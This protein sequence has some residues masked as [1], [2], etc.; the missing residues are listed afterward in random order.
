LQKDCGVPNYPPDTFDEY[1]RQTGETLKAWSPQQ[2]LAF[3]AALAERWLQAYEKFSAAAGQG[4]PA[5]LRPLVDAV[6]DHLRGR[7]LA[8]TDAARFLEQ[9]NENAPDTEAFDRL[10]AWRALQAC[11]ILALALECCQKTENAATVVKAVR[12]AFEAVLGGCPS[13]LAGQRRAW[14]KKTVQEEFG[15]QSALIEAI[16]PIGRFDDQ[17]IARLRSGLGPVVPL[18]RAGRTKSPSKRKRVDND[19]IE[20]WCLAVRGYLKRS[21]E[22]R[23]AFVAALAE[24]LLPLYQSFVAA[25]GQGRPELL[26]SVLEAVWQAAKGQPVAA[27]ALQELQTKLQKAALDTR[28]SE[29]WGAWSAWRLVE[30]A[31]ACCGL[32]ENTAP[33]EEAAVVAY[34]CVAGPG[35]R[36]DPQIWKNQH[37]RPDVHNEIMK[38]MLLLTG[39]RAMP[40]LDG[41]SL[42]AVRRRS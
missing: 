16:D 40:V 34:E 37:R 17:A 23:I 12:A 41:Q 31:L 36:N 1:E 2:R 13:D 15:K 8:P 19:S 14:K 38:Q 42:E 10:P 20:G 6:W 30:L 39:L 18:S 22:H 26:A 28:G 3:V 29:A 27:T 9:I 25:T 21:S 4:D 32:A 35:S 5:V 11:T 7:L 24:R 33:A